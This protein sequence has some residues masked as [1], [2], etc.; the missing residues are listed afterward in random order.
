VFFS[1]AFIVTFVSI[2]V[3]TILIAM[4]LPIFELAGKIKGQ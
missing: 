2:T 4:Y 1:E 3:G